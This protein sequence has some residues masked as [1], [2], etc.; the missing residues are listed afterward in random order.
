VTRFG[1]SRKIKNL[2]GRL[3]PTLELRWHA[4][5]FTLIELLVV[6]AIIALLAAL[7]LPA[8]SS[9]KRKA[10]RIN[11]VSN[12]RQLGIALKIYELEEHCW[13]LAT[14]GD[15]L[16]DWQR[17]LRASTAEKMFY[18]PQL[19]AASDQFLQYFPTNKFIFPHYGYNAFGT[20]QRNP[21][22]QNPGLGGDFVWDG[23]GGGKYVPARDDWV[24]HP[25]QMIAMGDSPT[26][27]RPPSSART[28]VTPADPIYIAFPF[29]L[30]PFGYYG[31]GNSHDSGANMVFCDGHTESK[32]Q[33]VWM[34][35]TDAS[36][37]LWNNDNQ[38]HP[39]SW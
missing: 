18:C 19:A 32:R 28:N 26:F 37:C 17:V 38:P 20:V 21:P 7:I 36:K 30:Q 2:S 14:A 15:G 22:P 27:V 6:L 1:R 11:C 35:A 24:R 23:S 9:A 3:C 12:L 34:S 31:V 5:G 4:H 25:D 13:P 33:T 8:L 10:Q 29:V 16:G 39:E